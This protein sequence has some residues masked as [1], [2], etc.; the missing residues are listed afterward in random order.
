MSTTLSDM[1]ARARGAVAQTAP[2]SA[3]AAMSAGEAM[4]ID[5]REPAEFGE[6]HIAGATCIPRGLLE[7]RA[8][9]ASPSAD[10]ALT[11]RRSDRVI[12]YCTRAP[13]ARSLLA[14]ETLTSMGFERVEALSGG[15]TAWSE[16]GLPVEGTPAAEGEAAR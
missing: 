7:L 13:G 9:P 10:A 5:V 2:E 3:A 14:A 1:I 4:I 15:L 8:D 11:G 12:L 16:A 6:R